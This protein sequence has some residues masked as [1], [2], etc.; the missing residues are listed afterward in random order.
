VGSPFAARYYCHIL[1]SSLVVSYSRAGGATNE[2]KKQFAHGFELERMD[3]S[4]LRALLEKHHRAG[5]SWAL[6]CC[7]R[8]S[9]EAE[10]VLQTVYLKVLDGRAR[11]DGRSAFRTWLFAVIRR[12][13]ADERR[14]TMLGKLRLLSFERDP[15]RS[16]EES[17]DEAVYRS[18]IQNLF[19]RALSTLSSRQQEVLQLVFYH[20]LSVAEAAEVMGVSVGSAR[21]HYERG[22]RRLHQLISESRVFDES[23]LAR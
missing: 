16:P 10:S 15:A 14:R 7:S 19:R 11:F 5:Y 23:R 2:L 9:T 1:T 13:A 4:E 22:K 18:Q 6:C 12:T 21:T 20:D 3:D 17:P 8:D